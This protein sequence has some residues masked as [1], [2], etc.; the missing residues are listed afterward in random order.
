[1]GLQESRV[2]PLQKSLLEAD[3]MVWEDSGFVILCL[4][5]LDLTRRGVVS[6]SHLHFSAASV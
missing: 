5:K 4:E 6:L 1:M 2:L 3:P